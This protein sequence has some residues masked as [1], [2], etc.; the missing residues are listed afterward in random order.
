MTGTTDPTFSHI[1]AKQGSGVV[2]E[3]SSC[4]LVKHSTPHSYEIALLQTKEKRSTGSIRVPARSSRDSSFCRNQLRFIPSRITHWERSSKLRVRKANVA[5]P[6]VN[7][8]K[9]ADLMASICRSPDHITIATTDSLIPCQ[10]IPR[11][12]PKRPKP[13]DGALLHS[14]I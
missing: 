7:D 3:L 14:P 5:P 6:C 10:V 13:L 11:F 2:R 1:H 8:T 4:I 9:N 12:T